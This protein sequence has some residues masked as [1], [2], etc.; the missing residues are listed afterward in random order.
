M[1]GCRTRRSGES[2][3]S[4]EYTPGSMSLKSPLLALT[5]TRSPSSTS[6]RETSPSPMVSLL[7]LSVTLLM[8]T[9]SPTYT[10]TGSSSLV[11][12]STN[13]RGRCLS[14]SAPRWLTTTCSP[15]SAVSSVSESGAAATVS[16]PMGTP[17]ATE[18]V[19]T[20]RTTTSRRQRCD[21]AVIYLCSRIQILG[22][23]SIAFANNII[24]T[25]L[26]HFPT[27]SACSAANLRRF[28]K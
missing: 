15:E 9:V 22:Y 5:V 4:A 19:T 20:R 16:L 17:Q 11:S 7:L 13:R 18:P 8:S 2:S 28:I 27:I 12:A 24:I 10:L 23:Y 21:S 1:F 26:F 14:R 3:S 25:T 6:R